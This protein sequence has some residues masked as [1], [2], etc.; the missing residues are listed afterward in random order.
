MRGVARRMK[1]RIERVALGGKRLPVS[2]SLLRLEGRLAFAPLIEKSDRKHP[3]PDRIRHRARVDQHESC[4]GEPD[5]LR[6]AHG[7]AAEPD[8]GCPYSDHPAT[9]SDEILRQC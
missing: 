1:A 7:R 3:Y 4:N 2:G 6:P 5:P 8:H 9:S